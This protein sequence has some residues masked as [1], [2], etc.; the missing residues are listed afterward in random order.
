M[1]RVF[2]DGAEFGDTNFWNG[3]NGTASTLT[4]RSGSYSYLFGQVDVGYININAL[5]ELYFRIGYRDGAGYLS[6]IPTFYS[7]PSA[8]GSEIASLRMDSAG[9]LFAYSGANLRATSTIQVTSSWSLIEIHIKF[10]T[11]DGVFQVKIDGILDIDYTGGVGADGNTVKSL[12]FLANNT[13][14]N[15][16]Y[17]DDIALNDTTGGVDD[18][19]CGDGK[20]L[21]L[22]P[23][24]AG[25][26]TQL[27]LSGAASNY[28]AVNEVP[29]NSDTDY[30]YGETVGLYDLYNLTAFSENPNISRVW[31]EA[32]A[33]GT[34]A[35]GEQIRLMIKTGGTEYQSTPLNML[36]SY[37]RIIGPEYRTNPDTTVA[38]TDSDLDNLQAGAKI[39]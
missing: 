29:S 26:I 33:R 2:T 36:T 34:V 6:R 7:D 25:D 30:V 38:W 19:W 10:G 4:A 24:A 28:D 32:R 5:G 35:D 8:G 37:D 27:Y 14:G 11:S 13:T 16:A 9:Y 22:S 15:V 18:S 21:L 17:V 39:A 23:N 1:A 20:V 31:V 3:F 12:Y